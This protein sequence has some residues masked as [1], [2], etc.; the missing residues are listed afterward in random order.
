M[1]KTYQTEPLE[2]HYYHEQASGRST[3]HRSV[4]FQMLLLTDVFEANHFKIKRKAWCLGEMITSTVVCTVLLHIPRYEPNKWGGE[5]LNMWY[6]KIHLIKS[7]KSVLFELSKT[8]S[9]YHSFK[10]WTQTAFRNEWSDQ[11]DFWWGLY[12]NKTFPTWS[13]TPFGGGLHTSSSASSSSSHL[14]HQAGVGIYILIWQIILCRPTA[15]HLGAIPWANT[16]VWVTNL[17]V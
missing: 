7:I 13:I 3:L 5:P 12:S 4:S 2:Y 14:F 17:F 16:S 10:L 6:T 11:G 9:H 1:I 8:W 15:H